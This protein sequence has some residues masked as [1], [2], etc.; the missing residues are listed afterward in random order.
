MGNNGEEGWGCDLC[1]HTPLGNKLMEAS[2][3][4]NLTIKTLKLV[5]EKKKQ[6]D[7]K[8]SVFHVCSC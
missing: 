8:Y 4:S 6:L 3:T 5:K 7:D 2:L 1:S